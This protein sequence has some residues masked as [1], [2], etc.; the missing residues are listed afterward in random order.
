MK[1]Y[2]LSHHISNIPGSHIPYICVHCRRRNQIG[3][4]SFWP[5]PSLYMQAQVRDFCGLR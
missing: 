1:R 2:F 4:Y 5:R 3:V